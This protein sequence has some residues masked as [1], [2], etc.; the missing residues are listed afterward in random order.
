M[1]SI[2]EYQSNLFAL[3]T[4]IKKIQSHGPGRDLMCKSNIF[5]LCCLNSGDSKKL[6]FYTSL[7]LLWRTLSQ[8]HTYCEIEFLPVYTPNDEEKKDARLFARNVQQVM[9][10]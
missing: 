1:H 3:D 5:L 8:V 7:T 9:A 6:M 2:L 10:K 4:Q